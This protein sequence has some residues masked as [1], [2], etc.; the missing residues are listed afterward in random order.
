[1]MPVAS[2]ANASAAYRASLEAADAAH[3]AAVEAAA[4]TY[5][6][7]LVEPVS[8][9]AAHRVAL[10]RLAV[11][12]N[13][14]APADPGQRRT[15]LR[16]TDAAYTDVDRAFA[17]SVGKA[18]A[19]GRQRRTL[20][21]F[22][23]LFKLLVNAGVS[24][25]YGYKSYSE[26]SRK[27]FVTATPNFAAGIDAAILNDVAGGSGATVILTAKPAAP[28]PT[29]AAKRHTWLTARATEMGQADHAFVAA[30]RSASVA[31]VQQRSWMTA[32][33]RVKES[34]R[35]MG[36]AAFHGEMMHSKPFDTHCLSAASNFSAALDRAVLDDMFGPY[37]LL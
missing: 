4:A 37:P 32:M 21:R 34:L 9:E 30:Q 19:R 11:Q 18:R 17:A 6:A 7:A 10:E 8:P 36:I 1:M 5:R 31:R 33:H 15:W 23:K 35:S 27:F 26:R 22:A 25:M 16:V 20:R 24:A 14:P 29:D 3:R 28:V 12:C 13:V 2:S